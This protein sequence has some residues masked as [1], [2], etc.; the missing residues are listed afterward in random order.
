VRTLGGNINPSPCFGLIVVDIPNGL[1]VLNVS[2]PPSHIPTWNMLNQKEIMESI[3][4]FALKYIHDDEAILL[5]HPTNK[6][7]REFTLEYANMYGFHLLDFWMGM[8]KLKLSNYKKKKL[9]G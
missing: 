1:P 8:N 7:I 2:V 5:F 6:K 9:V 3:F 4:E